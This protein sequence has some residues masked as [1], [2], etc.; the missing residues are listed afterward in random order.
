MAKIIPINGTVKSK[1]QTGSTYVSEVSIVIR[2]ALH[3]VYARFV[4]AD[5]VTGL[6]EGVAWPEEGPLLALAATAEGAVQAAGEQRWTHRVIV[7]STSV[8]MEHS[9][10]NDQFNF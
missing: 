7:M 4:S 2:K 3:Y 5:D 6:E 10:H 1:L 9:F 8:K